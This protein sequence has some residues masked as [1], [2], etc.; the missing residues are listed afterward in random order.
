VTWTLLSKLPLCL[1]LKTHQG[2]S[3]HTPRPIPPEQSDLTAALLFN[4][5]R[6]VGPPVRHVVQ[7][8]FGYDH[9]ALCDDLRIFNTEGMWSICEGRLSTMHNNTVLADRFPAVGPVIRAVGNLCVGTKNG[10]RKYH[11]QRAQ[12]LPENVGHSNHRDKLAA[13]LWRLIMTFLDPA[14]PCDTKEFVIGPCDADK[15]T[16]NGRGVPFKK[17]VRFSHLPIAW[18]RVCFRCLFVCV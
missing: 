10:E 11:T 13:G 5:N 7:G 4:D 9:R 3:R 15:V 17:K 14:A 6:R 2:T 12:C 1:F 18:A 16:S 8:S